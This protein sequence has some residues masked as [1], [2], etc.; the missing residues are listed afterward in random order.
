MLCSGRVRFD[1]P[2]E[3]EAELQG[4]LS[5]DNLCSLANNFASAGFIP[6]IDDVVPDRETLDM[7]VARLIPRPIL[8]VVLAPPYEKCV[9]RNLARPE[10]DRV[11]YDFRENYALMRQEI[12]NCGWWLDSSDQKPAATVDAVLSSAHERAIVAP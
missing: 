9:Q 11:G 12:G 8:L 5:L 4:T 3:S 10:I 7:I 6:V 2:D 1:A